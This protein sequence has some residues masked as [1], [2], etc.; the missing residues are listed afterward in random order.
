MYT[1]VKVVVNL[2]CSEPI[3]KLCT[4]CVCVRVYVLV[5]MQAHADV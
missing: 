2:T 5:C 3:N 1:E 4:V